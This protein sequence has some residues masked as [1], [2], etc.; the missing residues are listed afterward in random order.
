MENKFEL[1]LY[2]PAKS[3][4]G[5]FLASAVVATLIATGSNLF[6]NSNWAFL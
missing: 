4:P 6:T 3:I 5:F 1:G 2:N